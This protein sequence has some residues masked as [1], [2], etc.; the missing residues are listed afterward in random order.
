MVINSKVLKTAGLQYLRFEKQ[1]PFVCTEGGNFNAD[2]LGATDDYSIELEV[3]ISKQDL[4][5]DNKKPKHTIYKSLPKDK[6]DY[7]PNYF[8]YLVPYSLQLDA[9]NVCLGTPYGVIVCDSDTLTGIK[10]IKKAQIIHNMK[11]TE[12]FKKMMLLRMSSELVN[13]HINF[14]RIMNKIDSGFK[15]TREYILHMDN[16]LFKNT[17]IQDKVDFTLATKSVDTNHIEDNNTIDTLKNF[18]EG[19]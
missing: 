8:Y 1:C 19:D 2:V 4:L 17:E 11:P 14:E 18:L 10:V 6:I 15:E 13:F 3:K 16:K 9:E 5:Q 12:V 7:I